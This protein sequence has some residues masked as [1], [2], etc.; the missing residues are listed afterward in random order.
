MIKERNWECPTGMQAC[1]IAGVANS[2]ECIDAITE[3]ESCGGRTYGDYSANGNSSEPTG[4]DCTALAGVL[5]DSVTCSD[6]SEA[7]ACKRG[8][9]LPDGGCVK[10]FTFQL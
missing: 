7:F 1:N 4:V 3:L 10:T 5:R 9:A 2:W 6:S 8:W